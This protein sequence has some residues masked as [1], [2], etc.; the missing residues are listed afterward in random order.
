[1]AWRR[2]APYPARPM[3]LLRKIGSVLRGNATPLQIVL[4]TLFGCLLGF[5]PGLFLPG[6]LG[7]GLMQAPGLILLLLCVVLVL[8]ANLALFGLT[9]LVAKAASFVL[10]PVS[11]AIGRWL[12]D[13]PLQ[14]LFKALV[15]GQV[16][17]WCGLEYYATTGGIVVGGVAGLAS[18]FLVVRLVAMV[19]ARMAAVEEHSAAY[20]KF[21]Q[22]R[23]VRV[24]AWVFLGSGKGKASWADLAQKKV[25]MPIRLLGVVMA[26][27]LVASVWVFQSWFSKPILT[28]NVKSGLEWVNGATVDLDGAE[29]SL[30][31]ASLRITSLAIADSKSLR[32]DL[33]AADAV[34]ATI[35]TGE[36]LRKRLVIDEVRATNA[37]A[38]TGRAREGV[39]TPKAPQP[40]PE[41]A[42]AGTSTIEDYLKEFEQYK[43]RLQQVAEWI[44][45]MMP[46]PKVPPTPEQQAE[47]RRIE[48][49]AGYAKVVAH[50]LLEDAP[51][52]LIR[53]ID[54]EGITF[55]WNGKD[56]AFDLRARNL[57][58]A[59][60]LVAEAASFAM[61]SKSD[62]LLVGLTGRTLAEARTGLQFAWRQIPV[63]SVFGQL[64]LGGAPPLRGGTLDLALDGALGGGG[65][66]ARTIDLPLQVTMKDTL[67]ALAG[68]K[69]TAVKELLLPIG[70]RGPLVRPAVSLDDK[71][72][73][74]ALLKA[75]QA[76]LANFVQGQAG[77]LLG[78]TPLSGV[79]DANKSVGENLD[80]AKAKLEAE[81]KAKLDAEKAKAEAELKQKLL[82]EAK[83]K[84]PG[85]GGL[86]PGGGKE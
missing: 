20:Q 82:D 34:V 14:G 60:A 85:F 59:P 39:L 68:H 72:L 1:M 57:S 56:D 74:A 40:A 54:I 55:S 71:V 84:L 8:N 30:A 63:D 83:K 80:A 51:R 62:A 13:G 23:W 37:R 21:A 10:L 6:D 25:G 4:A 44:E 78:G 9:L 29:L 32:K 81:A 7:G 19:R 17:A 67:F 31:D 26:A 36:L 48:E 3:F 5:I 49:Q 12:L 28:R 50:H 38:G 76:E 86:L 58:D 45:A 53:K 75:G 61:K 64:K 52:I 33:L 73:Q 24:L 11:Y 41:P 27:V 43:E 15:N 47:Q 2:P 18:G 35:D 69:E 79:L 22:K 16:T 42:P 70:L 46:G 65:A 77:K 66:V